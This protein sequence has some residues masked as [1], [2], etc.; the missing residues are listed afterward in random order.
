MVLGLKRKLVRVVDFIIV[1]K[2][3]T[4]RERAPPKTVQPGGCSVVIA[5]LLV[6]ITAVDSD[7][8]C[9]I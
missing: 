5:D 6:K 3:R 4:D 7:T 8:K 1:E 2:L 9:N